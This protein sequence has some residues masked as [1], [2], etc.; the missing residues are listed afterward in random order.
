MTAWVARLT[1]KFA[2]WRRFL[3]FCAVGATGVVV[4]L[5]VF[6][7]A[8]AALTAAPTTL[9]AN[10]AAIAGWAVSVGTNFLLN[11][12]V[13]FADRAATWRTSRGHRLLRYYAAAAT[14]LCLQLAVLNGL[15]W[16]LSDLAVPTGS[17]WYAGAWAFVLG[18]RVRAS[19][20][21]GIGIGTVANYLLARRWVFR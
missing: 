16:L 8:M 9:R 10:L 19:N 17:T 14:G 5:G 21:V 12:R 1:G 4:N 20:V 7:A 13:T 15:L 2:Q 3:T 6:E 11:E 18:Q